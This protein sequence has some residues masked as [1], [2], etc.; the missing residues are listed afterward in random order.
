MIIKCTQEH[1]QKLINFLI[2]EEIY[3]TFILSDISNYG[4]DNSFQKIYMNLDYLGKCKFVYLQ[5]HN[6]LIL[7]GKE[8]DIDCEYIKKIISKFD[9][10]MGKS[11]LLNKLEKSFENI[12]Y[13]YSKKNLY[14]VKNKNKLLKDNIANIADCSELDNIHTFL[15]SIDEFGNIYASKEM[16]QKRINSNEGNHYIYK[17]DNEIV[18]HGNSAAKTKYSSMIGGVSTKKDYRRNNYAKNIVSQISIDLLNENITPC[19]FSDRD[20]NKAFFKDIGFEFYGH[21]GT[22]ILQ[23]AN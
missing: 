9:V 10:I 6:N 1:E 13:K 5:F 7:S 22:I 8:D 4:F 11:E 21:W 19:L 23:K 15:N 16:I 12:P 14:V 2:N 3:N 17:I 18:A 20:Y